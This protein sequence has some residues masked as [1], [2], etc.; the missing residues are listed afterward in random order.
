MRARELLREEEILP[1]PYLLKNLNDSFRKFDWKIISSFEKKKT[2][3]NWL[4]YKLNSGVKNN[5]IQHHTTEW[6]GSNGRM[7][8]HWIGAV[9]SLQRVNKNAFYFVVIN[10][11]L[12]HTLDS[13]KKRPSGREKEK[14][15][16]VCALARFRICKCIKLYGMIELWM[17]YATKNRVCWCNHCL[18]SHEL[19][20]WMQFP[21]AQNA[22]TRNITWV[23][24]C[25]AV[26][27]LTL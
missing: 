20:G 10:T 6:Y 26:S 15:V 5:F 7:H 14:S 12:N 9:V 19:G 13:G 21:G 25:A 1:P 22:F 23:C 2:L 24:V 27:S 8:M 18:L 11:V 16:F 3:W 4:S 17:Q